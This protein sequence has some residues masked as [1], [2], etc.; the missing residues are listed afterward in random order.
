MGN[1][2]LGQ[3][4]W[5]FVVPLCFHV[6]ECRKI[7]E[8]DLPKKNSLPDPNSQKQNTEEVIVTEKKFAG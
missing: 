3:E 7:S 8:T 5:E 2:C 1:F 6:L 4:H